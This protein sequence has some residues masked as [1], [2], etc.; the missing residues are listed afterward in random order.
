MSVIF[1]QIEADNLPFTLVDARFELLVHQNL[2]KVPF[3]VRKQI[4]T[5]LNS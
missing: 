1:I 2:K 5:N 3:N 4:H